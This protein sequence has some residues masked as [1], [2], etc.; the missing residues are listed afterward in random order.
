MMLRLTVRDARA[1][2]DVEVV[3]APRSRVG[4][5]LDLLPVAVDGRRCYVG[6]AALDPRGRLADSPLLDGSVLSVGA[7]AVECHPTAAG[8]LGLLLVVSGTDI[9]SAAALGPG[10]HTVSRHA[11]ATLPLRDTD[12]SRRH[13]CVDV[14]ADGVITVQ[15]AGSANGTF[16]NDARIDGRTT[17][18]PED[19]LRV[20]H[21]VV[22]W[23]PI[24]P[25][26]AGVRRDASGLAF[27]RAFAA[28]PAVPGIEVDLPGEQT[29]A[30]N[31][32]GKVTSFVMP[33]GLAAIGVV[34]TGSPHML[35]MGALGLVGPIGFTISERGQRTRNRRAFALA[36]SEVDGRIAAQTSDE[37]RIRRLRAPGPAETAVTITALRPQLWTRDV[38]S[39]LGLTLRVG[40]ADQ[41]ASVVTH[42]RPWPGFT[43]PILVA[44]PVTVDLRAVGVLGVVGSREH[45][46]AVLRWLLIQVAALRAPDNLRL[47][48]I[49]VGESDEL[50][51]VRWLPHLSGGASDV[52]CR[53]GNTERTRADRIDG[54][55]RLITSRLARRVSADTRFEPELVVVLNGALALRRQAG[56]AELL[57]DGPRVGVYTLCVDEH[58]MAECR[59]VCEVGPDACTL[60]RAYHEA[61]VTATPEGI[62]VATAQRL[63]RVLAP[64]RDRAATGDRQQTMPYPVRLLDVLDLAEPTPDA[65]DEAWRQRSGPTTRVVIGAD[66]NGPVAVDLARQGPHTML[67]GATGAGKSILLRTLITALFLAN[68]PD[69]LNLVLVDFKGGSAFLPF[70]HCAHVTALIRSTGESAADVFDGAAAARMLASI[71]AEVSR[72]ESLLARY[73]GE[74]DHY[75]SVRGTDPGLPPLPRLVMVFDEFARVLETSPEFLKELVKVAAKGR[76]LGIHLVLATQSLQGKLSPELKNNISLRISL[77]QNEPADSLEVLGVTDAAALPGSLHGRGLI[78]CTTAENRTPQAFQTGYLGDP[79][80][81][82]RSASVLVRV[83]PWTELGVP[84]PAPAPLA[85]DGTRTDQD[86]VVDAIVAAARRSGAPQPH[87]PL[88]PALPAALSPSDVDESSLP[89]TAVPF[90]LVDEPELQAQPPAFLD[91]AGRDQLMVAGGPQSGRTTFARTL[92]HGVVRRLPPDR[93][94]VY[95]VERRP[96]GLAAFA[97][98]PHCGGVFAPAE[99][100][101]IRRLITWLEQET[102]RRAAEGPTTPRPALLLV[103]DGWDQ[104]ENRADPAFTETSLT[105]RLRDII[106]TGSPHGVYVVAIGGPDMVNGKLANLYHQRLLLPFSNEQT[107][108]AHVSA[109]GI[110]PPALPGR[111]VDA[112]TG[113]HVQVCL[114]GHLQ[115]IREPA[116]PARLPSTFP[117]LPAR[118]TVRETPP[119]RPTPTWIPLGIGGPDL[120]PVG[121]DLFGAGPHVMLVSG[122]P[123]SGRTTAALGVVRALR[124]VGV[125][126][127]AIAPPRSPLHQLLPDDPGVR[128]VSGVTIVDAQLREIVAGFG[129]RYAVV[130]DDADQLTVEATKQN[131]S[132]LPTLLADITHPTS[133]G[134][135]ALVLAGDG[136]AIV[137][138]QRRAFYRIATEIVAAG[139][140]LLLAPDGRV[141]AKEHG[142]ALEP[143]QY[144]TGPPGRGYLGVARETTLVQLFA[145]PD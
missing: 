88:L 1:S 71:R 104:F 51:W 20:G 7:P 30:G 134:R 84:R 10:S 75:W 17:L 46:Q 62:T 28:V 3:A 80:P 86:L 61:P 78:L 137:S 2:V 52:P 48:V 59:G 138:G 6:T 60:T 64:L 85:A 27:D 129:D 119:T 44:A 54:L 91:L 24:A 120:A 70:E 117:A 47:M 90:G 111:A 81:S 36:R 41:P 45:V 66:A 131:F 19:D 97:E 57:R 40:V 127:L 106:A 23:V 50:D 100:D 124:D 82:G 132:E 133:L 5:V 102:R 58:A 143:D 21:D 4:T 92:I 101:R 125:N 15:D 89:G 126:V 79:P 73:D 11:R 94:H 99:A 114:P 63:A 25:G 116:D 112:T 142:F 16:V 26:A 43:P 105:S 9:G 65:V 83:L 118:V 49:T 67:G 74:I 77:R 29:V 76:S 72:R 87:R 123:E 35:W 12:V 34:T 136:A 128:S 141:V 13:A 32:M 68:R 69:E 103:I 139:A 18:T 33:L 109:R 115:P 121:I 96:S 135:A 37:L 22:R 31:T 56:I 98:L 55:H 38:S 8:A 39:P 108:R 93:A 145:L 107:R 14:G 130:V 53:I 42:G 110:S 113:R 144:L 122:P 140:R 95:V